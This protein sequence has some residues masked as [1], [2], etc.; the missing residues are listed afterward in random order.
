MNAIK[1]LTVLILA[2]LLSGGAWAQEDSESGRKTKKAQSMS[3]PVYKKLT[4]AQELIEAKQVEKGL[5]VLGE[6]K[7]MDNLSPY[8]RAQLWNYYAYTYFTLERYR[9]AINAYENVLKQP[10]LPE[11]LRNGTLYTLAQLYFTT[12]EYKKAVGIIEEWFRVVDEPTEN[13]YMLLGQGYYQLEQYKK[14]LEPLQKAMA[15][16]KGRGDVPKENLYLLLRVMYFELGDYKNMARVVK[17]MLGHYNKTEYWMTLAG[18]YSEMKQMDKQMSIMEMLYE[19]GELTKENQVVNL[20]NLYLLHEVPYKAAKVMD[21]GIS[22]GSIEPNVRHLR[23]LAQAWQQAQEHEKSIDPLSKAAAKSDEGDLEI[24]LAQAFL[25]L[26]RYPEAAA[27]VQRGLKKGGVKRPD[28]ANI[29]LGLA[30]F[31]TKKYSAAKK[32]FAAAANDKR[33]AKTANQWLSYIDSEVERQKAIEDGL[34]P[35][36]KQIEAAPE[37]AAAAG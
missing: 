20:A 1:L 23:L 26:D 15:L 2:A 11:G 12:E 3:E 34:K 37:A 22:E 28:T 5:A 9:D 35:K 36:P 19:R 14:A 31:E 7:A 29:M 32:A 13:A 4:E 10:E 6:I 30:L 27:A 24:R 17:E 8:E 18:A 33:S 21:K 16:V 25:N